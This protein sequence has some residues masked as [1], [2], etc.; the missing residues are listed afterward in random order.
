M[1]EIG[2]ELTKLLEGI[3]F[4]IFLFLMSNGW[5]GRKDKE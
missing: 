2:P 5:P 1:I 4:M 3:A